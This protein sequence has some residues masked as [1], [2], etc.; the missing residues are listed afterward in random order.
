VE[1]PCVTCLDAFWCDAAFCAEVVSPAGRM[2]GIAKRHIEA[3]R[4]QGSIIEYNRAKRMGNH[5]GN[6][7]NC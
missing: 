4:G 5:M 2:S 1:R 6:R 7:K 3:H